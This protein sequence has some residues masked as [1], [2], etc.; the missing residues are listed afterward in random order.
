MTMRLFEVILLPVEAEF[1]EKMATRKHSTPHAVLRRAVTYRNSPSL[2]EPTPLND[3]GD[4]FE[5]K[6]HGPD[7]K[8]L[9]ESAYRRGWSPAKMVRSCLRHYLLHVGGYDVPG[10]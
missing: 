3:Y 1:L 9:E 8:E 10:M 7:G 6:I 4:T 5:L 2:L